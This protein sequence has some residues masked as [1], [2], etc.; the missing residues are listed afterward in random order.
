MFSQV[1]D[2]GSLVVEESMHEIEEAPMEEIENSVVYEL[3]AVIAH[4]HD[5]SC[6]NLVAH[7]KV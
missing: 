2:N 4:I 3:T 5:P 1:D 7:V 6:G